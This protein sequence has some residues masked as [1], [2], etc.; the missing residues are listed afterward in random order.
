MS[1]FDSKLLSTLDNRRLELFLFPTEQCNFRC[2]Y[3]Y[4]DFEIGRMKPDVITGIKNLIKRRAGELRYLRI[5]WFGG[6]PLL[7]VNVIEEINSFVNDLFLG[8]K[9]FI[10]ESD[11]TTNAYLLDSERAKKVISLGVTNFQISLDGIE[12]IHDSTRKKA[13]GLGT[14]STIWGNLV[15]LKKL[16][17]EFHVM[18][19]VHYTPLTFSKLPELVEMINTNF[20]DDSRYSVIFKSVGRYGGDDDINITPISRADEILVENKLNDQILAKQLVNSTNKNGDFKICYAAK[21]NAYAI[22]ADGRLNKCTV[23]LADKLNDIGKINKDGTLDMT[24]RLHQKWIKGVLTK[25]T[26]ALECPY[27]TIRQSGSVESI[28]IEL[29]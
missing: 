11:M 17:L 13:N 20:S 27:G 7:A 28:D 8:D 1:E 26:T 6:E 4:E 18:L 2:T 22:R 25:D 16:P 9:D 19:R 23:A 12:E 5:S 29:T 15:H 14:F 24:D 3:C 10:F 21:P